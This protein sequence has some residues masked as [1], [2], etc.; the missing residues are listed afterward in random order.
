VLAAELLD[1][2]VCPKSKQP[3]IYFPRGSIAAPD[4]SEDDAF[5]LCPASRLR[6]RVDDGIPVLLVDEAVE[7][8]A[9]EVDRLVA[10]AAELGL[11]AKTPR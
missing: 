7:L 6:Y 10:R 4:R 11:T 1:V 8:S 3:L 9:A 5:L 2:L